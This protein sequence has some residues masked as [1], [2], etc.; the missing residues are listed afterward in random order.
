MTKLSSLFTSV[1]FQ[2]CRHRIEKLAA[3]H[4][5]EGRVIFICI[6]Y[7]FMFAA[8]HIL[9]ACTDSPDDGE[10]RNMPGGPARC[11][12]QLRLERRSFFQN[13]FL[14]MFTTAT[15]MCGALRRSPK[16]LAEVNVT[17][18]L[19]S[20]A[21][22]SALHPHLSNLHSHIFALHSH[23][24]SGHSRFSILTPKISLLKGD[25]NDMPQMSSWELNV[26]SRTSKVAT[27]RDAGQSR[28]TYRNF[29]HIQ[30]H[31]RYMTA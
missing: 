14:L 29:G 31:R 26:V 22:L 28:L 8:Q 24:S 5:L 25:R 4:P 30:R 6:P 23:L 10:L 21:N 12:L 27:T 20:T 15:T 16:K 11:I 2:S 3:F 18:P 7:S 1:K 13:V 19:K 9:R 17:F